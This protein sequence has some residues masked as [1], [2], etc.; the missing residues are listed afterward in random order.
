MILVIFI[1]TVAV[2]H[3]DFKAIAGG[4]AAERRADADAVVA[5]MGKLELHLDDAV[6]VLLHREQIAA[7]RSAGRWRR[8]SSS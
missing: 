5:R 6:L 7:L 1:V 4:M 8:L 3:L 2:Q